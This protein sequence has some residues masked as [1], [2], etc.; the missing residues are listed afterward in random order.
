MSL[1]FLGVQLQPGGLLAWLLIGLVAGAVASRLVR[2]H[3]MGCCLD[4]V[5]GIVGAFV[6]G[7]VVGFF[8]PQ[9]EAYGFLGS[10]VVAT[11][12][13]IILLAGLRLVGASR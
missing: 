6:G 7:I 2:G 8:V 4:V 13:A 3:G 5:L 12:G 9:T 10:L 11:L 1:D